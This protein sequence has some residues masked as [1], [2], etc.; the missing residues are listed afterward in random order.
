MHL[1]IE[2]G[3]LQ[4]DDNGPDLSSDTNAGPDLSSDTCTSDHES[5]NEVCTQSLLYIILNRHGH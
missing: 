4:V 3:T 5:C 1:Q 2:T